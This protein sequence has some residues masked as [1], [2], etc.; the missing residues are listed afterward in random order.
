MRVFYSARAAAA[1]DAGAARF[2]AG[3]AAIKELT[4][5]GYLYGWAVW[6]KVQDDSAAGSG[7]CWYELIEPGTVYGDALGSSDCVDCHAPGKDFLL[8]SGE[9]Q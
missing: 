3:A 2:P 7:F 4:S 9:H 1:L 6:V 5:E 8:S